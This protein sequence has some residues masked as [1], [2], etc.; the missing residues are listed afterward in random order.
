MRMQ[1]HRGHLWCDGR[2]DGALRS[3]ALGPSGTSVEAPH[4]RCSQVFVV[5][6]VSYRRIDSRLPNT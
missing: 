3:E 2:M 6:H 4:I 5:Q 1:E